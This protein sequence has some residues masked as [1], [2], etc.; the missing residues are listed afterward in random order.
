MKYLISFDV[1]NA[2]RRS[3]LAK[4]CL[5][6]G[7]RV[8]R[9]VFESY[10]DGSGLDDFEAKAESIIDPETDSVRVYP[11][12]SNA[13]ARIRIVGRGRRVESPAFKVL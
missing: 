5:S 7:F 8:Q 6:R 1:S 12:D 2:R 9:S 10:M 4:L 13:D 3:A 11:I